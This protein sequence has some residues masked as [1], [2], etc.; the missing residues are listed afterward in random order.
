[1]NTRFLLPHKYKKAGWILF[2]SGIAF[3]YVIV[4]FTVLFAP[5]GDI[6]QIGQKKQLSDLGKSFFAATPF[7]L[8][9]LGSLLIGGMFLV[10]CSKE[11]VEDELITKIRK[12][13]FLNAVLYNYVLMMLFYFLLP[14]LNFLKFFGHSIFNVL[15]MYIFD[16]HI[17]LNYPD[18]WEKLGRETKNLF[19]NAK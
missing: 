13:S 8:I 10:A 5:W 14:D 19:K 7:L 11:K 3:F 1:M 12:S 2:C 18:Y 9:V 16:F 15:L 17:Q 4:L 6:L